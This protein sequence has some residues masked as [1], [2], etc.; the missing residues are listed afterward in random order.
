[1]SYGVNSYFLFII[2]YSD[3]YA[4]TEIKISRTEL[5]FKPNVTGLSIGIVGKS[6]K[7]DD[8]ETADWCTIDPIYDYND[9]NYVTVKVQPYNGIEAAEG[10]H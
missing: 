3:I 8:S 7:I 6:W 9:R 10:I 5:I 2:D 1:M 4:E